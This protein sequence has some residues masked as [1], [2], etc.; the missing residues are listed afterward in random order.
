MSENEIVVIAM[1]SLISIVLVAAS[2]Y[3]ILSR[4]YDDGTYKWAFGM[5]GFISGYW[6]SAKVHQARS[7]SQTLG[8]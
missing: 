1:Q 8:R 6:L 4:S 5:T 2:L 7:G 3:I